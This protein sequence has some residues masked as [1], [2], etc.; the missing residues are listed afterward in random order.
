VVFESYL[1]VQDALGCGI[2]TLFLLNI[3]LQ[4]KLES[5]DVGAHF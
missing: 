1:G 4:A 5:D 2:N 3:N